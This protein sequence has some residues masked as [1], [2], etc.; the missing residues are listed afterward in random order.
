MC[1]SIFVYPPRTQNMWPACG[2]L[3]QVQLNLP[4]FDVQT[5][6]VVRVSDSDVP[7]RRDIQWNLSVG[8]TLP[9]HSVPAS[10]VH[11]LQLYAHGYWLR[12]VVQTPFGFSPF[13]YCCILVL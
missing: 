4:F 8:R 2:I 3:L 6:P 12:R 11:P 13:M 10:N 5:L 7:Y 1:E 9:L